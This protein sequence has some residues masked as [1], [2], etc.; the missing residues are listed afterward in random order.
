MADVWSFNTTVRNPERMETML[1][2]LSEIEG[3][4]FDVS[5]QEK[6]FGLLI[7]KRLYTPTRGKLGDDSLVRAVYET[8]LDDD[9]DDGTVEL[10]L[11][12]YRS[13]S[14]DGAG[15]GRTAAGILNRFGLCIALQSNGPVVITQLGK[16]W[17]KG[18]IDDEELF[19][20][21]FLKWQY[22]NP[23]ETGYGDFD[24]KP[25]PAVVNLID[26]VNVAWKELGN[27]PV[28]LS[29]EEYRLFALALK[30]KNDV[31]DA[32]Q[33][34]I[35]FRQKS[36][37]LSGRERTGYI[38]DFSRQRVIGIYGYS[39]EDNLRKHTGDLKDY[40]DSSLRYFRVS[41]LLALRGAGRYV[42]IAKDKVVEARSIVDLV[43]LSS[44]D[45]A[46][47][48]D[49]LDYLND[50]AYSLPWENE[51]ALKD[52]GVNLENVLRVEAKEASVVVDTS[53]ITNKPLSK[54][55]DILH[56]KINEVR[57]QKL[58][59]LKHDI[60]VLDEA[61]EKLALI[62]SRN[63]EPATARPSLDF[64]W[65]VSRALMVLN[66]AVRIDPSFK[67][68]DDGL[69]TGFR[70]NL[71][72]IECEYDSFGMTVEVTLLNGRDQWIAEGQPVMRHL[73]D[74]E[75][76]LDSG[77]STYSLFV[78]PFIHRDTL[79]TFWGSNKFGYE[80]RPQKIIPLTLSQFIEFLRKSREKIIL[81]SLNHVTIQGFV[82]NMSSIVDSHSDSVSW[83]SS[84]K[85]LVLN[86]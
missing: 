12:K 67:V 71:S 73:R 86:W 44:I 18:K 11:E 54:Q 13:G 49:Y 61:I 84:I 2:V 76:R 78:A 21:F 26:G 31:L 50:S 28:G 30:S 46:T 79:N 52:I 74:F 82:D 81:N 80:G 27:E 25:F 69:P 19:T 38:N 10:I 58:R 3:V 53:D 48:K 23:I 77:K 70:G 37:S 9:I 32:V 22:P 7:K 51:E 65:Y 59:S 1:R 47:P 24:V 29:K 17:L 75:D 40:A 33:Q 16:M 15:R 8:N 45:F 6:F 83:Q 41:G 66:D 43:S 5:G 72:D 20:K 34:I 55:V 4:N 14:V 68:G 57:I 35:A 39:N 62:T 63:Y 36:R 85:E 42:D 56:E 64:E 60:S